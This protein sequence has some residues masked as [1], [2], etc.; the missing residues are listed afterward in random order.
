MQHF[1]FIL[2]MGTRIWIDSMMRPR[3]SSRR[4]NKSDSVTV[5]V[6]VCGTSGWVLD[7]NSRPLFKELGD[8]FV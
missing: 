7:A 3:S 6:T 5:T 8:S 4:L 1:C 2:S